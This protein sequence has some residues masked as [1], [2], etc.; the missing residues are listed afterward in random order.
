MFEPA[1]EP[2]LAHWMAGRLGIGGPVVTAAAAC[3][4]SGY[5]LAIAKTWL[6]AGWVDVC[7][8]GGC[9]VLSPT[10]IAA[11]Y[12]LRALSRR[13]DDPAKASR[14]FDRDRD[15]FVMGEGG[16]FFVLERRPDAVARGARLHGELA[17]VP[18]AWALT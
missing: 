5:A 6:E 9:D 18:A 3:A 15:G 13:G 2:S 4:S 10:A 7:V 16:A 1:L 12:N 17:G 14:P 11:F 8:A